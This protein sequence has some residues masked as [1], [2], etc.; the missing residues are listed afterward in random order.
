MDI[1]GEKPMVYTLHSEAE[2]RAKETALARA[3]LFN[4]DATTPGGFRPK[5]KG[6]FGMAAAW[7]ASAVLLLLI[8]AKVQP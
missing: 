4:I 6:V 2:A 5:G 3:V 8:L 1:K 7:I